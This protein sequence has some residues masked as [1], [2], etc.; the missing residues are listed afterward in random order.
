MLAA[1]PARSLPL[2]LPPMQGCGQALGAAAK[3]SFQAKHVVKLSQACGQTDVSKSR[4]V[5]INLL[6]LLPSVTPK[7]S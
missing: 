4:T 6:S 1:M 7:G 2:L 3:R 5:L